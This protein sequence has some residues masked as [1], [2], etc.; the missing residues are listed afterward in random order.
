MKAYT[1]MLKEILEYGEWSDNRTGVRTKK[2][3]GIMFK[4]DMREGFPLLTTKKM[5]L[6]MIATE[7]EFFVKGLTDKKWLQDRGCHIWDEWCN[8][9]KVPYDYDDETKAKMKAETDLGVVYGFQWRN[10]G[11]GSFAERVNGKILSG[12]ETGADQLLN[13][14][15]TLQKNPNDRRM[16]CSAWNPNA[17]DSMALPPCHLLWQVLSNGK[18]I[19]LIWYQRSCDMFLG[20]PYNIASYALLLE[21]IAN[22][23]GMKPR[24]LI[25]CL[26]DAHIYENHQ[27]QIDLQLSR[28]PKSL[29][30]LYLPE[31]ADILT[32]TADNFTLDNYDPH[33]FIKAPIAV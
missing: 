31:N 25:G 26:A 28:E 1:D 5:N 13:I 15:T 10:F 8:P 14:L 4:H 17:L 33:P 30:T 2:L 6:K 24:R 23:I 18:D 3:T 16:I 27:E 7:L 32:W 29:P 11:G 21:L 20:V 19:D 12:N 9:K 22:S